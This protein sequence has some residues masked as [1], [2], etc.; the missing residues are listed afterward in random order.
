MLRLLFAFI[1]SVVPAGLYAAILSGHITNAQ[2]EGIPYVA[3]LFTP[4]NYATLSNVDGRFSQQLAPGS[5]SMQLH[6]LGYQAKRITVNLT[7]ND[8]ELNIRL[9]A[10]VYELAEV[11]VKAKNEDPAYDIMRQAIA[12]A[13]LFRNQLRAYS[14]KSYVKGSMVVTKA[15][16]LVRK[17]MEQE[18]IKTNTTYLLES[19][20]QLS[21]RQP[22]Q[23]SEKVISIRS[24]LPPALAS[25]STISYGAYNFYQETVAGLNSPL[26][27][28]AFT[29]YRFIHRGSRKEG[30]Y[31]IHKI[32]VVPRLDGQGV[33]KGFLYLVDGSWNIYSLDFTYRDNN[34]NPFTFTQQ[35]QPIDSL[36]VAT[37]MDIQFTF[38]YMGAKANFRYVSSVRDHQLTPNPAILT[39]IRQPINHAAADNNRAA[40][41][42]AKSRKTELETSA[43]DTLTNDRPTWDYRFEIDTL[44]RRQPDSL[45]N[46]MRQIPLDT[47]ELLGYRQADSLYEKARAAQARSDSA[48]NHFGWLDPLTAYTYR[49]GPRLPN[50]SYPLRWNYQGP[51]TTFIPLAD[52]YNAVEGF[53]LQ[54]GL[55]REQIGADDRR[56]TSQMQL[57]YAFAAQRWQFKLQHEYRKL[58]NLYRIS[59]G[60]WYQTLDVNQPL[61][62]WLNTVYTL[63]DQQHLRPLYLNNFVAFELRRQLT[64][65]WRLQLHTEVA[66]RLS[67]VVRNT[68]GFFPDLSQINDN[69]PV[70]LGY[71][72]STFT[73]HFVY[74]I[75]YQLSWQPGA[76]LGLYNG[77]ERIANR[78]GIEWRFIGESGFADAFFQKIAVEI[79]QN[80]DFGKGRSLDY[81]FTAGHFL[82][83]PRYIQDFQHFKG[84]QT[85]LMGADPFQ[86]RALPYYALSSRAS[87]FSAMNTYSTR[88][89]LLTQWAWIRHQGIDEKLFANVLLNS[90]GQYAEGGYRID[91]IAAFAGLDLF[92]AKQSGQSP[93]LGARLKLGFR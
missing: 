48:P 13:P 68:H 47:N 61:A 39:Q 46:E 71:G 64:A 42:L 17:M 35:Y 63:I 22:A 90:N 25:S 83:A 66:Y 21:Y 51:F 87:F 34:G 58:Y 1:L 8:Q 3:I 55:E 37:K 65:K 52:F 20:S 73:D 23:F 40:S 93:W 5:Y 4:G 60:S 88:R 53:A 2:G 82:A 67:D 92:V 77:K 69:A 70:V 32:E 74:K 31:R 57:R 10:Q 62:P 84:N 27:S 41:R 43:R 15:P 18:N 54:I 86:F 91:R 9:D 26:A 72:P 76:M 7:E 33:V 36:W 24:N 89:L 56:N 44:A 28:N 14:A 30:D 11:K 19:V 49:K 85:L 16:W 12:R 29:T 59:A 80:K 6:C 50:G 81:Q 78:G 75:N 45:W 79:A 38:G